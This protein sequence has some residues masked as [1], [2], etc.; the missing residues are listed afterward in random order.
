MDTR[1][2]CGPLAGGTEGGYG[3]EDCQLE[4]H[5]NYFRYVR[6][7]KF[8]GF[9]VGLGHRCRSVQDETSHVGTARSSSRGAVSLFLVARSCMHLDRMSTTTKN[10]HQGAPSLVVC[11]PARASRT[12]AKRRLG[13]FV[14]LAMCVSVLL[15]PALRRHRFHPS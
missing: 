2:S 10:R 15:R 7:V 9:L 4:F 12:P 13:R 1:W 8:G 14:C 3:S 11:S 6:Q 5:L